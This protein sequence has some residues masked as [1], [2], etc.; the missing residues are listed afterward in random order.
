M[1]E[2]TRTKPTPSQLLRECNDWSEAHPIGQRVQ[3]FSIAG[4]A[5]FTICRTDGLAYILGDHSAVIRLRGRAGCF[6]LANICAI[7]EEHAL[8]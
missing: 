2:T 8:D 4:N 1:P 5:E 7:A 3:Y 6:A